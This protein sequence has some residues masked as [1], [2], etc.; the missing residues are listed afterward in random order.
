[1]RWHDFKASYGAIVV[2]GPVQNWDGSATDRV[3]AT[4]AFTGEML[5]FATRSAAEFWLTMIACKARKP[6]AI[7][8]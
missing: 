1:M 2:V 5:T 4:S 7:A 8:A 3:K 6:T